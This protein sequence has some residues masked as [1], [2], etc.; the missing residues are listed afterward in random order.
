VRVNMSARTPGLQAR[1]GNTLRK[2]RAS[3]ASHICKIDLTELQAVMEASERAMLMQCDAAPASDCA[4]SPVYTRR[5]HPVV[6]KAVF[7]ARQLASTDPACSAA[8]SA[9]IQ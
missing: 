7:S 1:A 8:A 3:P 6:Y 9:A 5:L 2:S 4:T